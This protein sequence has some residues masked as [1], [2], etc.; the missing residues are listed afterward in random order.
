DLL[1]QS[2]CTTAGWNCIV[3]SKTKAG[4][5]RRRRTVADEVDCERSRAQAL[6]GEP[7]V[8]GHSCD[9]AIVGAGAAGLATAI[10]L[11]RL[12]P[13]CSVVLVDS[14]SRPGAKILISG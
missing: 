2:R 14:A 6:P 13:N 10:F 12:E 4:G 7:A 11:R 1:P 5:G 9:V 3:G 8:E